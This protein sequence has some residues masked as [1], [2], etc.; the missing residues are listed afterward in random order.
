MLE[1]ERTPCLLGHQ[2]LELGLAPGAELDDLQLG[3]G[4]RSRQLNNLHRGSG[5]S[6][7]GSGIVVRF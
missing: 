7:S 1:I 2:A 4:F 3:N 6:R 5:N